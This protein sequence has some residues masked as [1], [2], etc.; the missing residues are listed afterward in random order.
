MSETANGRPGPSTPTARTPA[1]HL[2]LVACPPVGYADD[3]APR[4]TRAPTSVISTT[5]PRGSL[6]R[7]A[8]VSLLLADR[9][10]TSRSAGD[11]VRLEPAASAG[12]RAVL[13]AAVLGTALAY[14][15]DDMLNLAIPSVAR[16]LGAS[17][18]DV[19]WILNSYY[20]PLVACV[21]VAG[22]VGDIL[23]HRRVFTAGLAVFSL[24]GLAC[25]AAPG[26]GLLVAGRALQGF[27]AAMLLAAGLALVTLSVSAERR[28]TA[29]GT[30]FGAVAAVPALGPFASGAL[31]DLLSWRWL[32]V[33]PLA[34][35]LTAYLVVRS[36]VPET[37]RDTTRHPDLAGAGA[38][39]LVLG[40][41]SVALI[42]APTVSS[43][44]VWLAATAVALIGAFGF[45]R[46]ERS[47][48]DPL[49]PVRLFRRRRFLGGN[50]VWLLGCLTSWGAVFFLAV[51]LQTTLGL[52]PLAAGLVLVPIYLVLMVGSPLAGRLAEHT[53][54]QVPTVTGL[55]VYTAGLW[56]LGGLDGAATLFPDVAVALGVFSL[57]MATFTAPLATVT[58]TALDDADQGLASGVNNAMG[59]LAG[60]LAIAL[61]PA[62]AGLAGVELA[63]PA[64][65]AGYTRA[66]RAAALLAGAALLVA[67]AVL[68]PDPRRRDDALGRRSPA[69]RLTIGR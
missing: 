38:A 10:D 21:L 26:V 65:A 52:R 1:S 57:G 33:L 8:K 41:L 46:I 13:V 19:Q 5:R 9:R 53:G 47:A 17:M 16:D 43:A 14:M 50:V 23:G 48:R 58:M 62:V 59:Q 49:L 45:A 44:G 35:P 54:P 28:N 4:W 42:V 68:R 36:R 34:L 61:L 51:A 64:F 66:L 37:P 12:G 69:R 31:V 32:F 63:W 39:L 67:A 24:G 11:A 27:G 2:D 40:G 20:V 56:L 29:I 15:S 6:R 22:S 3:S 18:T 25:A 30:F 60:L 55:G 7:D